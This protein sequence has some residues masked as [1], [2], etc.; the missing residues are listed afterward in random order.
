MPIITRRSP[1]ECRRGTRPN[2]A[3]KCR[4]FLKSLPS[5]ICRNHGSR[6]LRPGAAD[7]SDPLAS[8]ARFE[9]RIDLFAEGAYALI[10]LEHEG[11][12][13]PNNLAHEAGKLAVRFRKDLWDWTPSPGGCHTYGNPS[14]E[15]QPAHLPDRCRTMIDQSPASWTS[16]WPSVFSGTNRMFGCRSA[17]Q[18]A[19]ASLE[20]FFCRRTNGFTYWGAM[21]C[22]I[23]DLRLQALPEGV[24]NFV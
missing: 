17:V 8:F 1:L 20:S 5:P 22:K 7:L 2:H 12:E 10:G 19:S 18:I 23:L 4:P 3:V 21:I 15:E 16:C 6:G 13:A 24:L 11:L 14:V 9:D